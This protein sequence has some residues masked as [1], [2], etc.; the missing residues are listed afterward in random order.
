[1]T[2]DQKQA[3]GVRQVNRRG[4]LVGLLACGVAAC[5]SADPAPPPT[6]A[7]PHDRAAPPVD[8][9]LGFRDWCVVYPQFGGGH[10]D[11]LCPI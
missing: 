3:H 5:A 10:G 1:M 9:V 7:L 4:V 8:P 6:P 11:V 2:N